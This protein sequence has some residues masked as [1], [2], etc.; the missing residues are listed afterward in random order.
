MRLRPSAAAAARVAA[1]KWRIKRRSP[2]RSN[3]AALKPPRGLRCAGRLA[4][5]DHDHA[6]G[7]RDCY[8]DLHD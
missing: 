8:G 6:V 3:S 5:V 4:H 2:Q 7:L 1:R